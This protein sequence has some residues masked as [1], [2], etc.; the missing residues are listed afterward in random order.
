MSYSTRVQFRFD[1]SFGIKGWLSLYEACGWYR[2][3]TMADL[4][5]IR[6]H[7]FLVVTAW[8]GKTIIGTLTVLSDGR[9]YATIDDLVV[10]PDFRGQR[11]GSE[12]VRL[13][14]ARLT[15]IDPGVVKLVSIP[16]V[17]PFYEHLGFHRTG[18]TVMSLAV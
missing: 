16:G 13:A 10:H 17:E 3:S 5:V 18:E 12:L 7:A 14:L 2:T 6:R 15:Y 1:K 9:N 4:R 11:I 8:R